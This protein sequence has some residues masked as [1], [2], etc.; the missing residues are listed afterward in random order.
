MSTAPGFTDAAPMMRTLVEAAPDR[1]IWGSDHPHL[2]FADK[3]GT[4]ELFNL[5]GRWVPDEDNRHRI[6]VDNPQ[7]LFKLGQ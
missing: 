6:L 7:K 3:V 2:S 1:L 5:F 4:V